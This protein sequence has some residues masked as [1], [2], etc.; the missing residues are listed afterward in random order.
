M[1]DIDLSPGE[2][3]DPMDSTTNSREGAEHLNTDSKLKFVELKKL[4][5]ILKR[6]L[7]RYLEKMKNKVIVD[8]LHVCKF[9]GEAYDSGRELGGHMSRKHPGQS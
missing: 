5:N 4:Y 6:K 2:D 7:K 8:H 3:L 1:V 9:C